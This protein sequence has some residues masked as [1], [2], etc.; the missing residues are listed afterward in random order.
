MIKRDEIVKRFLDEC[1]TLKTNQEAVDRV[2][3]W[4]ETEISHVDM[5][6]ASYLRHE[7]DEAG[8]AILMLIKCMEMVAGQKNRAACLRVK[9]WGHRGLHMADG[10]GED[11]WDEANR[12]GWSEDL[13]RAERRE[14]EH[15]AHG[16]M[17][18][19]FAVVVI[20]IGMWCVYG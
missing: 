18:A 2:Q 14:A 20:L 12:L 13:Q 9:S 5:L 17:I 10:N 15:F 8:Q 16:V 3:K 1:K 6:G 4:L 19:A 11:I 7:A